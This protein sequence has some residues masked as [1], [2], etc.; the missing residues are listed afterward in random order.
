MPNDDAS[1][2]YDPQTGAPSVVDDQPSRDD[3]IA[4]DLATIMQEARDYAR[5]AAERGL[6]NED[7]ITEMAGLR[8]EVSE[9]RRDL[10]LRSPSKEDLQEAEE[11]AAV[12]RKRL[13]V[14]IV[15]GMIAWGFATMWAHDAHIRNCHFAQDGE[16]HWTCNVFFPLHEHP[17]VTPEDRL[18]VL[19]DEGAPA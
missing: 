2:D 3:A 9:L 8:N 11:R 6:T 16:V 7:L 10:K 12:K 19:E 14:Y 18:E 4:T 13:T 1:Q 5:A 17:H 15:A